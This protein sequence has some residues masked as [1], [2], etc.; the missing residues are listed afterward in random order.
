[1]ER[2][3]LMNFRHVTRTEAISECGQYERKST[4]FA[5]FKKD[6]FN[7][8]HIPTGD[9]VAA[10]YTAKEISDRCDEHKAK[11]EAA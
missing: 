3:R 11:L 5:Q 6:F 7:V 1:M 4:Y 2:G 9:H 10:G 8:W